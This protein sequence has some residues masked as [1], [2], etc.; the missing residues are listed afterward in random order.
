M[1]SISGLSDRHA[2]VHRVRGR[3]LCF[4][5]I[6]QAGDGRLVCVYQDTDAHVGTEHRLLWKVSLDEGRTWDRHRILTPKGGHCPRLSMPGGRLT[7]ID[8]RP[9]TV[10]RSPD[11]GRSWTTELTRGLGHHIFDRILELPK[12]G[13]GH[14]GWLTTGH[15]HRGRHP[16]PIIRQGPSE[17][18]VY[19]SRDQGTTWTPLSVLAFEKCLVL[20]EASVAALPGG[21]LLAL[22]RENSFVG[23][24]MHAC[25]SLDGGRTWSDPMPTPL[26]GH[27]PSLGLTA[28]GRLLVTWRN[29]GPAGGTTAWLGHED[30]LLSGPV[31]HGLHPDPANPRLENGVMVMD[32]RRGPDGSDGFGPD[33][34]LFLLPAVSHPASAKAVLR[35]RVM[36]ARGG[37]RAC[38]LRLGT[39]WR[40]LPDRI[41][42]DADPGLSVPLER[43]SM[44]G[45]RLT[46]QG[47]HVELAVDGEV[48]AVV[49]VD[50][51]Q[52]EARAVAFGTGPKATLDG[53]RQ[54]GSPRGRS[55]WEAVSLRIDE[56]RLGLV[57]TWRWRARRALPDAWACANILELAGTRG[58]AWCDFGYSGWAETRPGRFVC[59]Y[60]HADPGDP[61]YVPGHTSYVRATRFCEQDWT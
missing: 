55:L 30:D 7:C 23:E 22:L 53:S 33:H 46:M 50:P 19:L 54:G 25:R 59:A 42:C 61:D 13:D 57:K 31:A 34:A 1:P 41:R 3:Y 20:C 51:H 9:R 14:G 5:D 44:H 28:S 24:P 38:C 6:C 15:E 32:C 18:M 21:E 29:L 12:G 36:A 4:P 43:G 2:T 56:P 40:I 45:L 17:Q 27:R 26:V 11:N 52:A 35:A 49:P 16:Q 10:Y 37:L 8:E 48:R 60:H 47:G 39:W 58:I